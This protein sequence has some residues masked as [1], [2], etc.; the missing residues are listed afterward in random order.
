MVEGPQPREMVR[1]TNRRPSWA[2]AS[3]LALASFP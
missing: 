2:L 1:T 3:V